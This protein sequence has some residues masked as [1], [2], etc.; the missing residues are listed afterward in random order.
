[1]QIALNEKIKLHSTACSNFFQFATKKWEKIATFAI[2][3][4]QKKL[5]LHFKEIIKSKCFLFSKSLSVL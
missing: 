5:H 2:F 1:M 3:K 4:R